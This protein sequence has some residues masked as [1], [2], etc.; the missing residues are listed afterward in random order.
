MEC[1]KEDKISLP[2]KYSKS[3]YHLLMNT[4][5]KRV[6]KTRPPVIIRNNCI[7]PTGNITFVYY[8][9]YCSV[10]LSLLHA[11]DDEEIGSETSETCPRSPSS[12]LV[13]AIL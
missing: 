3:Y 12:S 8:K 10:P 13:E 6:V 4:K 11:R 7:F 1:F 2:H 9:K 5:D